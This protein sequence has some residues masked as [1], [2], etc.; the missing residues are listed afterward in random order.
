MRTHN[1]QR[2]FEKNMSDLPNM[3]NNGSSDGRLGLCKLFVV[4]LVCIVPT[5]ILCKH[6]C[7]VDIFYIPK[8]PCTKLR[9][10]AKLLYISHVGVNIFDCHVERS[11][12]WSCKKKNQ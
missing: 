5:P 6:L 7:N 3:V 10:P 9:I 2:L 12:S 1:V 4:K 8:I 11:E